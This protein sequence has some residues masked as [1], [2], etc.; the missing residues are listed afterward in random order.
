[1]TTIGNSERHFCKVTAEEILPSVAQSFCADNLFGA[2]ASFVGIVREVN[3]GRHVTKIDYECFEK[4]ALHVFSKIISEAEIGVQCPL[5]VYLV[6]R[7]GC[8]FVGEAS[9]IVGVGSVHRNESF[10]A[11]RY[12]IEE[13]KHRV[14]IWKLEHYV[15]GDSGWVKG[16]SLC[17]HRPAHQIFS[18]GARNDATTTP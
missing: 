3:V 15:D 12:I 5:K 6:H 1:M 2:Y 17:Q 18:M 11:C 9:V 14:P 8:L 7:V 4:L 10:E 13:L 16:H